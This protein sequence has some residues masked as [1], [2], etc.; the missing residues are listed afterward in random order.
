MTMSFRKQWA[1][2]KEKVYRHRLVESD[3]KRSIPLQMRVLLKSQGITQEGLAARAGLTQGAISRALNPNYGNLSINTIVRIAAGL[4][5]AFIGRF[6]PFS[7]LVRNHEELSEEV[8]ADVPTFE[9]EDA[10]FEKPQEAAV[11]HPLYGCVVLRTDGAIL[12]QGT[13]IAGIGSPT[14]SLETAMNIKS[15]DIFQ[16][17]KMKDEANNHVIPFPNV[18]MPDA[19]QRRQLKVA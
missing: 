3:A 11:Q 2:L 4:D 6:V 13:S 17:S 15:M 5:V 16:V 19:G 10:V 18:Q 14:L 8:L 9:E 12:V 1:K 7:E